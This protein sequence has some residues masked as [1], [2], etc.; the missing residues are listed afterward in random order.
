[1]A[2][3]SPNRRGALAQAKEYLRINPSA[4]T[5][6]VV[7]ALNISPRTVG[8]ARAA[9][10]QMGIIPRS[11]FDHTSGRK[12]VPPAPEMVR[13]GET[14]VIVPSPGTALPTSGVA[15]LEALSQTYAGSGNEP[16]TPEEQRRRLSDVARNAAFAGNFQLEIAAIQALARLDAQ[17]GARDSL[18]PGPPLTDEDKIHRLG[19]LI[20]ACGKRITRKALEKTFGKDWSGGGTQENQTNA[21]ETAGGLGGSAE[22]GLAQVTNGEV[23][24]VSPGAEA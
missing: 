11:Y 8:A 4:T 15:E 5:A 2:G 9:L 14:D 17:I 7:D 10:V 18:G 6:Q 20:E 23:G 1:L 24:G 19:L 21:G 3:K 13:V 12:P 16:L 22:T